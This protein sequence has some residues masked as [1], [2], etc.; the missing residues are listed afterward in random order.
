MNAP[1][2]VKY[3]NWLIWFFHCTR[4]GAALHAK[5]FARLRAGIKVDCVC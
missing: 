4:W 1:P 2:P 5:G 3:D